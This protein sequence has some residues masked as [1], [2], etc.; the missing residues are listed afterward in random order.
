[1]NK[2]LSKLKE[3]L[4]KKKTINESLLIQAHHRLMKEYGWI[5]LEEFKQIPI[6]TAFNLLVEIKK[7][8]ES[9]SKSMNKGKKGRR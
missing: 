2:N 4:I 6:P 1:M 5:P 8:Y 7:E 9:M 3:G